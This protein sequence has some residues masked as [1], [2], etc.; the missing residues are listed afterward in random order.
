MENMGGRATWNASANIKVNPLRSPRGLFYFLNIF[1]RSNLQFFR[2][3]FVAKGVKNFFLSFFFEVK[4]IIS[5]F[6]LNLIRGHFKGTY[7]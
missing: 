7:I 3:Y 6:F 4:K 5:V 2:M 1:F